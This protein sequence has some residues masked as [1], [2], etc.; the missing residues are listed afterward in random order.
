MIEKKY[1]LVIAILMIIV[2]TFMAGFFTGFCSAKN[3]FE[4]RPIM[5]FFFQDEDLTNASGL[6]V[7]SPG[8]RNFQNGSYANIS[9]GIAHLR[10][11]GKNGSAWGT[12]S[13]TQGELPHNWGKHSQ[14]L[15][16]YS[17]EISNPVNGVEFTRDRPLRENEYLLHSTVRIVNRTYL[18][19]VGD[20]PPKLNA[21]ITLYCS[22]KTKFS[23][24]LIETDYFNPSYDVSSA[25]YIDIFF[26]SSKWT[27]TTLNQ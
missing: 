14:L 7:W 25:I 16:G 9:D 11:Y 22:Y 21:G 6:N 20:R 18:G 2:V 17:N 19:N 23:N 4:R 10:Y 5:Y 26:S 27:G 24:A 12:S 13:L 1:V 15:G 3:L 8:F